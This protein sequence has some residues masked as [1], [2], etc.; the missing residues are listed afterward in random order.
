MAGNLIMATG[1]SIS[2]LN[3]L[4]N[5]GEMTV[6]QDADGVNWYRMSQ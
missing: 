2:H 1:E 6:S 4:R 3:Y 5:C